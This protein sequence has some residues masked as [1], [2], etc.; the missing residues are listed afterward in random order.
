MS[1]FDHGC[2][3]DDRQDPIDDEVHELSRLGVIAAE[4][5]KEAKEKCVDEVYDALEQ[6][7][8]GEWADPRS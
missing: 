8:D 6:K 5:A 3:D 2:I 7:R 1:G 4:E